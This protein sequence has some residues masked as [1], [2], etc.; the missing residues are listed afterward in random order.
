MGCS[1]ITT[2]AVRERREREGGE[3]ERE[4]GRRLGLQ[5]LQSSGAYKMQ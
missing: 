2:V 5:S 4:G 1:S 3:R